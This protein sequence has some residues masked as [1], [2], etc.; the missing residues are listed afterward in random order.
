MPEVKTRGRNQMMMCSLDSFVDDD[1]IARVIDAFVEK[2]DLKAIGFTKTEVNHTG[3]SMIHAK[4]FEKLYLYG[5]CKSLRASRKLM[6]A[7]HINIEVKWLM[8]GIEPDFRTISEFRKNNISC[9]KKV[10]HEFNRMIASALPGGF[11]SVDG[12]KIRA[13]NSKDNNFTSTKLD[14]RIQWLNAKTEE[15][16]RCL[17][18]ADA[19]DEEV[20]GNLTREQVEKKLADA[21][22]RLSKYE[23]Y[24]KYMEENGL[25]QLS[26]ID[27]D[28]RLMKAR[29]GFE[30]AYNLQTAVDAETHLIKDFQVTNQPTDHA[31]LASTVEQEKE[32]RGEIIE[33]VADAGYENTGDMTECLAKGI[34]PHV[35]SASGKSSFEL[36]F[37]YKK[38]DITDAMK[39][40]TDA[41]DIS[42][43]LSA[44]IVPD[45]Y[46][47]YL[48][49]AEIRDHRV[50]RKKATK[51]AKSPY[52]TEDEM[53]A[54]ASEGYFVRD[55][56]RNLVICPAGVILRQK[57]IKANGFIRYAN[58]TGCRHCKFR[59]ICY[60]G[61]NDFREIDFSK[62]C[63]EKPNKFWMKNKGIS[64][65][66]P[67]NTKKSAIKYVI[68]KT[69]HM[70]F[71]PD[72]QKT[73]KRKCTSEHPFGTLK[74]HRDFSRYLLKGKYKVEG[75]TALAI[76]GYN[77]PH[78]IKLLGFSKMMEIMS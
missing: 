44:G 25:S 62:D 37:P 1:S 45:A 75:E 61:K 68:R 4:Y 11:V 77:I 3:R 9:M 55:P 10:F 30:V 16:M 13:C 72:R 21:R 46:A 60:Q 5:S 34:I 52:A 31:L 40:S 20:M 6:E 74:C 58:K 24:S 73:E 71:T 15:Y 32:R 38:A 63:L 39:A 33:A 64:C 35:I 69:V 66:P 17:E 57:S 65:K 36:E 14:D 18:E 59:N 8:D 53:R 47:P 28:A 23:G 27:E 67:A 43:C 2:L 7:C 41:D 48:S 50:R 49:D 26:L 19:E 78:A 76:M 51:A 42:R 54:R 56:E 12:T 22:E 29:T 70:I